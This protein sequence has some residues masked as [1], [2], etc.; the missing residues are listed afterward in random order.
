MILDGFDEM[1]RQVDYQT[2]VDNFWQ[3]ADLIDEGSKVVLTSRTEYFR[4]AKESE[5]ILAGKE[6]G[7]RTILLSPPKFEV[8]NI[9]PFDDKRIIEALTR[10]LGEDKGPTIAR[11]ILDRQDLA[12]MIRKPVLLELV[13]AALDEVGENILENPAQ[14]YLYATNKL[15]LRN[16]DTRRTFTTTSDKLFFLCELAWEMIKNN[17]LTIHYK[18]IPERIK[19]YFGSRISDQHELDTWD[20][21]LRNQTLLHRNAAGYYEFAH[22][23]LAEYFVAFK[24]AAELGC[25]DSIFERTYCEENHQPCRM[26]IEPKDFEKL[27]ET[28]GFLPLLSEQMLAIYNLLKSMIAKESTDKLWKIIYGTRGKEIEDTG[29]LGCNAIILLQSLNASFKEASLS[30]TVLTGV[31]F[32][33]QDLTNADMHNADM[34]YSKIINCKLAKA[35]LENCRL[36]AALITD[37]DLS[38]ANIAKAN[39]EKIHLS[40]CNMTRADL[41]KCNMQFA[42]LERT[43]FGK[44]NLI[45]AI[46]ENVR[47]D[48]CSLEGAKLDGC[49]FMNSRLYNI[50]LDEIH[51]KIAKFANVIIMNNDLKEVTRILEDGTSIVTSNAS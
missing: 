38:D 27:S 41:E 51:F 25:I 9:E 22:K 31:E 50:K 17:Q 19:L 14:V 12:E 33:N 1:A 18:N 39:L 16:I 2:V 48:E 46:L 32:R 35:N 49:S 47:L 6:F 34:S 4:W 40:K 7:R 23:S 11:T 26:P 42:N 5:K 43:D 21:D 13:L 8:L 30:E 20:F 29:Y 45:D 37:T 15:L 28:F 10:R 24:L 36:Q 44:A 3:L